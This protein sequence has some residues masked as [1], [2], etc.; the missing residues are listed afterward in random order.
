MS[1]GGW[2]ERSEWRGCECDPRFFSRES[3]EPFP[4][5]LCLGACAYVNP[6]EPQ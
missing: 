3:G 4:E 2:G 6:P 1:E 5:V